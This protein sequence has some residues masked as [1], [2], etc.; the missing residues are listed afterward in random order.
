MKFKFLPSIFILYCC[1]VYSPV[2]FA[3]TY[4]IQRTPIWQSS[5]NTSTQQFII[6]GSEN[7][8]TISLILMP[9]RYAILQVYTQR[10]DQLLNHTALTLTLTIGQQ[11]IKL[12][13]STLNMRPGYLIFNKSLSIIQL[14]E[15]LHE[16]TSKDTAYITYNH[17]II[18]VSLAGTSKVV[19]ALLKYINDHNI[20][21]LPTP[22]TQERNFITSFYFPSISESKNKLLY[23]M[24]VL[25]LLFFLTKPCWKLCK[26]LLILLIF[27][28]KRRKATKIANREIQKYAKILYIRRD[29]LIYTDEY[30]S[31]IKDKWFQEIN[32]FIKTKI[33]PLLHETKLE[34]FYPYIQKSIFKTIVQ[35]AKNFPRSANQ[36]VKS[37]NK[38]RHI[39]SPKMKPL[40]YE[41]Y[42]ADLLCQ[43]GWDAQVTTASGDQGADVIA[44]KNDVILI[45][46]CKLYSKPV[47]NK[48]V[49]EVNAAKSFYHA[50]YTAVVSNAPYTTSARQLA[51]STHVALLHHE[52]LQEFALSLR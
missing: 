30:G 45:L 27:Y 50:H 48:A 8:Y 24:G 26:K 19:T 49:Q 28:Y 1:F 13:K 39:Y 5:T 10:K 51:S 47:G 25:T 7:N 33:K 15:F 4:T 3:N 46:Q 29:Q 18:P 20:S 6:S 44:M 43:I 23:G 17:D 52:L 36:K 2:S 34:S 22:F 14:K 21:N 11:I 35:T 42:C 16:L 31:L 32:R 38:Q 41:A 9:Q 12:P 37:K 40:D